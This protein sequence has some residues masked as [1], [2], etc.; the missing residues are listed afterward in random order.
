[1]FG[2]KKGPTR[3]FTH[4]DDCRIMKA[5]PGA[6][7]EWQEIATGH[8]VAECQCGKEHFHEDPAGRRVRLDPLDP[9]TFRH[10]PACD[11]GE[12]T[13]PAIIRATLRIQDRDGYWWVE[14]SMCS[15]CW[16][17]PYYAVESIG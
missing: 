8:W 11:Q 15:C 10:V 6:L 9:S 1:M 2:L 16:Q 12:V 17:V 13:D 7:I 14:S 4:A 3:P 5:D